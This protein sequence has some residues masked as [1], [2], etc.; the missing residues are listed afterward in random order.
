MLFRLW[1]VETLDSRV[2]K[3]LD[4]D[5]LPMTNTGEWTRI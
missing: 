4:T 5:L 1:G 2:D 3:S